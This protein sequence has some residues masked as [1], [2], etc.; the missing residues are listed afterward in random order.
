M[1]YALNNLSL[2]EFI[3]AKKKRNWVKNV[4]VAR[5]AW[6]AACRAMHQPW[7]RPALIPRLPRDRY[8]IC[9]YLHIC[10]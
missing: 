3:C 2:P 1:F 6:E 9:I 4:F 10:Q 5:K 7:C 8:L